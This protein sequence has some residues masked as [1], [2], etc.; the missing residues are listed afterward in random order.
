[1]SNFLTMYESWINL[2]ALSVW[3]TLFVVMC[4]I[5]LQ[6]GDGGD[7]NEIEDFDDIMLVLILGVVSSFILTIVLVFAP[8]IIGA[9]LLMASPFAISYGINK[10]KK[11]KTKETK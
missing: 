1:M 9:L 4:V 3:L 6:F 8:F 11:Q 7:E 5:V 10:I 2:Y